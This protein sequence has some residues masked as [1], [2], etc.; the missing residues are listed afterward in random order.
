MH[1]VLT[2]ERLCLRED[3]SLRAEVRAWVWAKG[4][5]FASGSATHWLLLAFLKQKMGCVCP[6]PSPTSCPHPTALLFSSSIF[7]WFIT[8]FLRALLK[9]HFHTLKFSQFKCV[10]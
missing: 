6:S 3:R 4:L 2:G 8:Y 9:Y 1:L 10:F 7:S 5:R